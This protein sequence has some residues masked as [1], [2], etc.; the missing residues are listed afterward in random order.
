VSDR[1][2]PSLPADAVECLLQVTSGVHRAISTVAARHDLTPQQAMTLRVLESSVTMRSFAAE[3]S[4]DPSN[5]TGLVDRLERLGLV[6][7]RPDPTDRRVRLLLLTAK[8]K[9][10]RAQLNREITREVTRVIGLTPDRARALR[11]LAGGIF[12]GDRPGG[13]DRVERH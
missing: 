13:G 2:E 7:R 6:E 11:D 3:L 4:C 5:V 1:D 8:G 9:R 10:L 12:P